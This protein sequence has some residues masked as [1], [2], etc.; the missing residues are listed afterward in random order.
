MTI[1]SAMIVLAATLL[2]VFA[3]SL[4]L[5]TCLKARTSWKVKAVETGLILAGLAVV[6][7]AATLDDAVTT[8]FD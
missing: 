8:L 3:L 5:V 4:T 6:F 1:I 7:R 2:L